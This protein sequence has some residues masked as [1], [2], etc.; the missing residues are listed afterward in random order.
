[1]HN[2]DMEEP[3]TPDHHETTNYDVGGNSGTQINRKRKREEDGISGNTRDHH[4][5][6]NST[7]ADVGGNSVT[8]INRKRKSEEDGNLGS[9]GDHHETTNLRHL[10]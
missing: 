6:T 5:T 2:F 1:M 3:G 8:Q 7:N 10:L 9:T 4:E